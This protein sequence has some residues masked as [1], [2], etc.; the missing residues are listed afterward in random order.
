MV[1]IYSNMA[2]LLIEQE[3]LEV[4][5]LRPQQA[6]ALAKTLHGRDNT[7]TASAQSDVDEVY[8]K[9]MKL[10]QAMEALLKR[11]CGSIEYC[12]FWKRSYSCCDRMRR[13]LESMRTRTSIHS[14]SSMALVDCRYI[15]KSKIYEALDRFQKAIDI[16][17]E[18]ECKDHYIAATIFTS[19]GWAQ[20]SHGTILDQSMNSYQNAE[21]I[22]K[23]TVG[24]DHLALGIVYNGH[25]GSTGISREIG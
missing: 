8:I 18:A 11:Q 10:E 12:S 25:R 9:E 17:V 24:A 21:E 14:S 5:M 22:L 23:A 16:C 15:S 4:A 20:K 13:D 7:T 2:M 19:I 1:D 6:L 3:E